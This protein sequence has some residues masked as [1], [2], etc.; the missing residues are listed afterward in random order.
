VQTQDD[1][2]TWFTLAHLSALAGFVVPFG[3]ILGPLVVW[4]VKRADMPAIE[5][6]AKEALNFQISMTIYFLISAA[7]IFAF[8]G[9]ALAPAVAI[10]DVVFTIIAGIKASNGESY[11]YP[12]TIRLIK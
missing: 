5:A 8:V 12:L 6:P 7:L 2:K 9:V 1:T 11:T 3:N 4:L 10:V